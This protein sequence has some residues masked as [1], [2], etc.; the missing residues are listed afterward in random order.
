MKYLINNF[1]TENKT[2]TVAKNVNVIAVTSLSFIDF[3]NFHFFSAILVTFPFPPI[4]LEE[5]SRSPNN[6]IS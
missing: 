4:S 3:P 1:G 2:R 6:Q 5:C